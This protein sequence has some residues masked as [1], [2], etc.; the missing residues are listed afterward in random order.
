MLVSIANHD[1]TLGPTD[2]GGTPVK[3]FVARENIKRFEAQLVACTD[4]QRR[5]TLARLLEVERQQLK[6][7]RAEKMN[8]PPVSHSSGS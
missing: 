1:S 8:V 7:A 5:E 2:D 6:D 4:P 3:E